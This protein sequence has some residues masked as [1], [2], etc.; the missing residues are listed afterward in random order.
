M[1]WRNAFYLCG[2]VWFLLAAACTQG[3]SKQSR[4]RVTYSGTFAEL[5]QKPD[6]HAGEVVLI[7]GKIIQTQVNPAYSEITVLQLPL[8]GGERP[9]LEDQSKGRFLIRSEQL[10]DPAVYTEGTAITVVGQLTG[11]QSRKVGE[12][13]YLYPVLEPIEIKLWH[14]DKGGGPSVHFGVSIFKSF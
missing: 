14:K 3:I 6:D 5:Q 8:G 9:Q 1:A 7:G 4:S 13:T 11:G 12:F 10:L 2:I